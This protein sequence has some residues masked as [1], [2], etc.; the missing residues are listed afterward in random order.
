MAPLGEFEQKCLIAWLSRRSWQLLLFL[1][2]ISPLSDMTPEEFIRKDE[3]E[4]SR[5]DKLKDLLAGILSVSRDNVLVFSVMDV[6]RRQTD[7]RLAVHDGSS[8]YRPEKLHGQMAAFKN[9]VR[10]HPCCRIWVGAIL[11]ACRYFQECK[12]QLLLFYFN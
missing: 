8:Y 6:D 3:L 10:M 1:L 9:K 11:V 7:V 5:H 2:N 4:E 12:M